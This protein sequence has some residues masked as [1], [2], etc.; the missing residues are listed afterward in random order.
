MLRK[1]QAQIASMEHPVF[2]PSNTFEQV[3]W[4]GLK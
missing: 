1:I 3:L 4:L 2:F